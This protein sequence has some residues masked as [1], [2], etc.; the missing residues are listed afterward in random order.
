MSKEHLKD[1]RSSLEWLKSEG[2]LLETDTEVDGDLEI[3]KWEVFSHGQGSRNQ[4]KCPV[5]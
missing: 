5:Q 3:N 1:L 2:L 4:D